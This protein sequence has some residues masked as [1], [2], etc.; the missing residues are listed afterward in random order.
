MNNDLF[1]D[2]LSRFMEYSRSFYSDDPEVH[3]AVILKEQHSLRVLSNACAIAENEKFPESDLFAVKASAL[4]HDVGRFYQYS[5]YRT[6]NDLVSENHGLLGHSIIQREI[7]AAMIPSGDL[8]AV[9]S[10]V[11]NHNRKDLEENLSV[12]ECVI[13]KVI[14]DADKLDILDLMIQCFG[15]LDKNPHPE[16][17]FNLPDTPGYNPEIIK[18]LAAKEKVD[19]KIR[20]NLNDFKLSLISWLRDLNYS[21]TKKAAVEKRFAERIAEYLPHDSEIDHIIRTIKQELSE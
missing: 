7:F 8:P 12:R 16:Y 10:A 15:P 13:S 11:R 18:R 1:T 5:K 17:K 6:F 14:R 2:L 20:N 19:N 4:L 21:Y 9:L 3:E